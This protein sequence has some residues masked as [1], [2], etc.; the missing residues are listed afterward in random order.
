MAGDYKC[1]H[2]LLM[3]TVAGEEESFILCEVIVGDA[4]PN[5]LLS[6]MLHSSGRTRSIPQTASTFS[7]AHFE[8]FFHIKGVLRSSFA[9]GQ[10][11]R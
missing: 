3:M 4:W 10:F 8:G 7:N 11:V 9:L 2:H 5:A 1:H 6:Y